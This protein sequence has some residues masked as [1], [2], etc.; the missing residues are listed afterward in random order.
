MPVSVGDLETSGEDGSPD[1]GLRQAEVEDLDLSLRRDLHVGGLKIPVDDPSLVRRF[2]SL[3]DLPGDHESLL[4]RQRPLREPLRDRLA[5]DE[6]QNQRLDAARLL[7][8]VNRR[9][10]RVIQGRQDL[11]LAPEPRQP[12]G[13]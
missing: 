3:R 13:V 10:V 8:T 9:D 1:Q 11:R 7:E 2:Q 12:L 5:G 6:F 4:D